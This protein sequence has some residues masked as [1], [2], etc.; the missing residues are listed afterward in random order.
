M[1]YCCDAEAFQFDRLIFP[2]KNLPA[3]ELIPLNR[4][5]WN[6]AVVVEYRNN[7]RSNCIA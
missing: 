5:G 7:I 2:K 6:A 3:R 4:V 1:N